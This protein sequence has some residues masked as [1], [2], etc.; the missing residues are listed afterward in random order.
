MF[1]PNQQDDHEWFA[2]YMADTDE[3]LNQLFWMSPRQHLNAMDIFQLRIHD[4][5]Y[6]CNRFNLPMGFFISVNRCGQTICVSTPLTPHEGS[7]DYE[8]QYSMYFESV[9]ICRV[10]LFMDF[11][12][13]ATVAGQVVFA[14][15]VL[16]WCL[17]H[18]LQ[19]IAKNLAGRWKEKGL[20]IKCHEFITR[21]RRAQIKFE[22]RHFWHSTAC[23]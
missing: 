17:W 20:A 16:I 12:H 8:W 3:R 21:F 18:I 2:M 14:M 4:N 7:V 13:G 5:T 10:A 15:E 1:L 22:R 6:K 9:G 23:S 19:N 11:D